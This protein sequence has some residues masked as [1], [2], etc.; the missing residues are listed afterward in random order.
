MKDKRAAGARRCGKRREE[1]RDVYREARTA[2]GKRGK[3]GQVRWLK[4]RT[5]LKVSVLAGEKRQ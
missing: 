2:G 5:R 4:D 3:R 1:E